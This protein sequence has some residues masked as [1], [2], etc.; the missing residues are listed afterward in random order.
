MLEGKN[1]RT[2]RSTKKMEDRWFGPFEIVER[3]G[4]SAYKLKLPTGWRKVHPVFNEVLLKPYVSPSYDSQKL[5]TPRPPMIIDDHEEFEVEEILDSK[6]NARTQR[7]RFYI[8]WKGYDPSENSWE[9]DGDVF[10]P[11]KAREFYLAH[12]DADRRPIDRIE[13]SRNYRGRQ[14][15]WVVWKGRNAPEDGWVDTDLVEID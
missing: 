1:L 3:I 8:R 10:A 11:L 4:A 7:L 2:E 6:W 9:D 12:P 15:H 5:P 13:R 14:Q